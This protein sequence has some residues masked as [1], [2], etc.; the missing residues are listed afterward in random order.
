MTP[1]EIEKFQDKGTEMLNEL[2][3]SSLVKESEQRKKGK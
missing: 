3:K 1:E 2:K